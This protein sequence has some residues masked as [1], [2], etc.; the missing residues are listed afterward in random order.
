MFGLVP[1]ANFVK[2]NAKN[3]N[4]FN[5]L[6]D[7]FNEPFF[8]NVFAPVHQAMKSFKVDVKDIGEA[9]ELTAELPG[10]KKEDISLSYDNGYLTVKTVETKE[11]ADN[12]DEADNSDKKQ[13]IRRERYYGSKERSFY[14]DDIDASKIKAEYTDGILKVVLP[15]VVK[16]ETS[17]KI[18]IA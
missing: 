5:N 10:L 7:V 2:N 11:S 17:T 1:F 3:D 13:Y 9:Y 18:D 15:K 16:A 14:I 4:G 6:L 12:K 8:N